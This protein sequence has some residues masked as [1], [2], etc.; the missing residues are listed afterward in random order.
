MNESDEP[1]ENALFGL[2]K[3][4]CTEP[5]ESNA[6]MTAISDETGYFAFDEVP[7]GD[8]LSKKLRLP[9]ATFS[10]RKAIS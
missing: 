1:L 9:Q 8:I 7:Y 4:D 2:F 6:I 3:T 10:V 5:V